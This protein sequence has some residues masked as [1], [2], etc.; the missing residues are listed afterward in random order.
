MPADV[1]IG[2]AGKKYSE[3]LRGKD[4]EDGRLARL[5]RPGRLANAAF[6]S[7]K[8]PSHEAERCEQES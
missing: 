1:R 6:E 8:T 4:M 7:K 5:V 3:L 2:P